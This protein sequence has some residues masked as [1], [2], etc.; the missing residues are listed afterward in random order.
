VYSYSPQASYGAT[1][2]NVPPM[3]LAPLAG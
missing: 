1:A 2:G 3:G